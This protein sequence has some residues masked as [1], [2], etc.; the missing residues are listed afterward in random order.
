MFPCCTQ[1]RAAQSETT[2]VSALACACSDHSDNV[3]ATEGAGGCWRGAGPWLAACLAAPASSSCLVR[4]AAQPADAHTSVC[5]TPYPGQGAA[6][7]WWHLLQRET[8]PLAWLWPS[9]TTT[10]A[11]ATTTSAACAA[12]HN[13]RR[14]QAARFYLARIN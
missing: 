5:H 13:L 9:L 4:P 7:S 3:G 11:S 10:K 8:N 6:A 14:V 12:L 2:H 1:S